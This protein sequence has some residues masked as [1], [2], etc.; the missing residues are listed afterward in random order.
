[1]ANIAATRKKQKPVKSGQVKE[2]TVQVSKREGTVRFASG[3]TLNMGDYNSARIDVGITLPFDA[4][5]T[6]E[7]DRVYEEARS[8]VQDKLKQEMRRVGKES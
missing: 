8:W 4:D 2:T 1:M 5:A 6:G 7:K 3:A